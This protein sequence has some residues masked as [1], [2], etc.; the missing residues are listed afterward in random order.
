M[1]ISLL[2]NMLMLP[3]Q[4]PMQYYAQGKSIM[5]IIKFDVHALITW[6]LIAHS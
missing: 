4:S 5:I 3:C 6:I 1:L 2:V